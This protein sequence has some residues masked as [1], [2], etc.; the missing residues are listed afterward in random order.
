MRSG[1]EEIIILQVQ[2]CQ[3]AHRIGVKKPAVSK[4]KRDK[5]ADLLYKDRDSF[6]LF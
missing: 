6:C 1:L 4:S 2:L 3:P 5:A